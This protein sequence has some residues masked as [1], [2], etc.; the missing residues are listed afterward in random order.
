MHTEHETNN[1]QESL[2]TNLAHK[3]QTKCLVETGLDQARHKV[4]C[5][6]SR[7]RHINRVGNHGQRKHQTGQ[8]K[9]TS[10]KDTSGVSQQREIDPLLLVDRPIQLFWHFNLVGL[11]RQCRER[12]WR[13][14]CAGANQSDLM[15]TNQGRRTAIVSKTK[16]LELR[17][18]Q[19]ELLII[20]SIDLYPRSVDSNPT[21]HRQLI[22]HVIGHQSPQRLWWAE[23]RK[24]SIWASNLPECICSSAEDRKDRHDR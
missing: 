12:M 23:T 19:C 9:D 2:I 14:R 17:R 20:H 15:V 7:R 21:N 3:H 16:V 5:W 1:L 13:Q 18:N 22:F 10:P 8:G 6:R 11:S 4:V 24:Y